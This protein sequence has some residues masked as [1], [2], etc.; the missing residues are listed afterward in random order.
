MADNRTIRRPEFKTTT[1]FTGPKDALRQLEASQKRIDELHKIIGE[2]EADVE[3]L[4]E[5]EDR[6]DKFSI[7]HQCG[8]MGIS[9][10]AYRYN[11]EVSDKDLRITGYMDRIRGIDAFMRKYNDMT[12]HPSLGGN[13]PSNVYFRKASLKKKAA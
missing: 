5:L 11:P 7:T 6:G 2:K 13:T 4:K 10:N 8:L 12:K 9:R 1:V 3:F